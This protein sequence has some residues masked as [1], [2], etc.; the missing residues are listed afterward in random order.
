[1]VKKAKFWESSWLHGLR[2]RDVAPKIFEISKKKACLVSKALDNNFWIR[3]IDT[4][5]GLTLTYIQEFAALKETL[6]LPSA[7][8]NMTL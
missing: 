5:K 2:P 3:Q 8:I 4:S 6:V 7:K 1:M